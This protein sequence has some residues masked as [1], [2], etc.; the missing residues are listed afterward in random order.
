MNQDLIKIMDPS[1]DSRPNP[2]TY[3]Y[4]RSFSNSMSQSDLFEQSDINYLIKRALLGDSVTIGACGQKG[5]G[6]TYTIAGKAYSDAETENPAKIGP[7]FFKTT[8]ADEDGGISVRIFKELYSQLEN[9]NHDR[10]KNYHIYMSYFN[11]NNGKMRHVTDLY[12]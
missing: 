3:K 2:L 8:P 7:D 9:V 1:D 12:K 5:S 6:K 11:V 10:K 4:D